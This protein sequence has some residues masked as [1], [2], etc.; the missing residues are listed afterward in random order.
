VQSKSFIE[1][2][3]E[4]EADEKAIGRGQADGAASK[5]AAAKARKP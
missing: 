3:R 2:A 5:D 1:K 4:I